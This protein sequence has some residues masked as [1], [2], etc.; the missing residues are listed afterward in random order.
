MTVK[1]QIIH[2]YETERRPPSYQSIANAVKRSKAYV[3]KVIKE[4]LVKQE[5]NAPQANSIVTGQDSD[6]FIY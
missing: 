1:E 3:Y 4:S 6:P 2:I 5:K